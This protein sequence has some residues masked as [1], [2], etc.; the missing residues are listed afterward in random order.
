MRAEETKVIFLKSN[1]TEHEDEAIENFL[2][3]I[4]FDCANQITWDDKDRKLRDER[5]KKIDHLHEKYL[6]REKYTSKELEW[7]YRELYHY[8]SGGV[9]TLLL[10]LSNEESSMPV[11]ITD[12]YVIKRIRHYG[13]IR[14]VILKLDFDWKEYE[15]S[16]RTLSVADI[17]RIWNNQC[18][19]EESKQPIEDMDY[20]N[21]TA[22]DYL[23]ELRSMV[24]M[25][26]IQ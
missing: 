19:D 2:G 11:K 9:L 17:K 10:S 22:F 1:F 8:F 15:I 21:P 7:L 18:E 16:G 5:L 12:Q 14:D 13:F 25:E 20:Y 3:T 6:Y 24:S 26:D 23:E 4:R